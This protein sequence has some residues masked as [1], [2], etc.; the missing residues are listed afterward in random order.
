MG[1]DNTGAWGTGKKQHTWG[2]L[3]LT[4]PPLPLQRANVVLAAAH[5]G[6][7]G[8]TRGGLHLDGPLLAAS[9]PGPMRPRVL[10]RQLAATSGTTQEWFATNRPM[11]QGLARCIVLFGPEIKAIYG[12]DRH[13]SAVLAPHCV[14]CPTPW[15]GTW[16]VWC[17]RAVTPQYSAKGQ[18]RGSFGMY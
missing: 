7:V 1:R 16:R 15:A 18:W 13:F 17:S 8:S 10:C 2:L 4:L 14:E 12:S 3:P 5:V 11:M 6:A 9:H